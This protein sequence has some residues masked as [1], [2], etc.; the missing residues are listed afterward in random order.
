MENKTQ[1]RQKEELVVYENRSSE[2]ES[3]TFIGK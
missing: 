1:K 3:F 2:A